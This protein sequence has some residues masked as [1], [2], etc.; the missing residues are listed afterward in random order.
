MGG[1]QG[2]SAAWWEWS[3]LPR[4]PIT[5]QCC[6]CSRPT[7]YSNSAQPVLQVCLAWGQRG[8]VPN[9]ITGR[10]DVNRG[11]GAGAGQ[12]D[13]RALFAAHPAQSCPLHTAGG[14]ASRDWGP[15]HQG[16]AGS[17]AVPIVL[18]RL[19]HSSCP[20]THL[21]HGT[22]LRHSPTCSACSKDSRGQHRPPAIGQR[23]PRGCSGMKGP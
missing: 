5:C 13:S 9:S 14:L 4:A 3:W 23:Q 22:G 18:P 1:R 6:H 10:K 17:G 21:P 19:P 20:L 12:R 2:S 11:Q 15:T 16:A 8:P 7:V